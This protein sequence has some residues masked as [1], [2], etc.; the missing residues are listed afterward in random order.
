MRKTIAQEPFFKKKIKYSEIIDLFADVFSEAKQ[1]DGYICIR[2][3]P[4]HQD[5]QSWFNAYNI[6]EDL[7]LELARHDYR[8]AFYSL[9]SYHK[10]ENPTRTLDNLQNIFAF[11]IDIDYSNGNTQAH[12][13]DVYQHIIDHVSIPT[14]NYIE[15]GH[16]L[17]LIYIFREPLRL[18]SGSKEKMIKGFTFLQKCLCKMINEEF[19]YCD[20]MLESLEAEVNPATNFFRIPGSINTKEKQTIQIKHLT[21][22]R[23]TIQEFFTEYIPEAYLN[24][25][26]NKSSW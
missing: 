13:L 8:D 25:S 26:E 3:G 18:Y 5:A 22:E 7:K 19:D 1:E 10:S 16:C 23:Y 15:Y 14:P 6:S 24:S 21:D 17:R 11:G 20:T 9:G 4:S 2:S 12:P